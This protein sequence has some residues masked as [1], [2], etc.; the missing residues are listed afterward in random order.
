MSTVVEPTVPGDIFWGRR[1]AR[2]LTV[3]ELLTLPAD[4][5]LDEC[6]ASRAD[7]ADAIEACRGSR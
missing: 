3:D 7:V 2:D 1:R 6:A 5:L 4:E